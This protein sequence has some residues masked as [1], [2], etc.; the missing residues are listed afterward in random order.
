MI[1]LTLLPPGLLLLRFISSG[2]PSLRSR[3]MIA[4]SVLCVL[5]TTAYVEANA[6]NPASE[7]RFDSL[8]SYYGRKDD[9]GWAIHAYYYLNKGEYKRALELARDME[10][11]RVRLDKAYHL[12][13]I[14]HAKIGKL[15]EAEYY[16]DKALQLRSY[17]P[18]IRNEFG[19]LLM[20]MDKNELALEQLGKARTIDPTLTFIAEGIGLAYYHLGHLDSALA[21]ADTLFVGDPHSPGGYLLKMIVAVRKGDQTTAAYCFRQFLK[22]GRHRSDYADLRE[23][24]KYLLAYF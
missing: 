8:L 16:Y 17:N 21:I 24:Y 13:G 14:L 7:R 12:L 5:C 1:S 3:I 6:T 15:G 9:T 11:N 19:Q 20:K 22:Y 23:Y 10:A 4:Y 2:S 18:R